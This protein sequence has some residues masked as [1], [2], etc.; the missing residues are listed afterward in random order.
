MST[1]IIAEAGVNHNGDL[2]L[3]KNLVDIAKNAEA[4]AVKFQTWKT[5][6]VMKRN[7]PKAEYQITNTGDKETQYE[8]EKKLELTYEE[9]IILKEY[10]DQKK[11]DFLS[12]PFD[13]PSA[14]FLI[15]DLSLKTIKIPSG[16]IT[17]GPLL[18][19][20]AKHKVQIILSTGMATVADIQLALGVIAFGLLNDA[21]KKPCIESFEQA[22]ISNKGQEIL[23]QYVTL[24][25]CTTEYPAPYDSVNLHIIPSL[26]QTFGLEVGYSDHTEG[27]HVS[28]AAVTLGATV[29]EK[30]I[31]YDKNAVGPDHRA[32]IEPKELI[33]LI[34][35][36]KEIEVA[37]GKSV[38]VPDLTEIKNRS[39]ARKSLV[40]AKDIKV[41]TYFNDDNLD[42]K[43][44]G[45]GL[46]PMYY[47]DIQKIKATKDFVFDEE[48]QIHDCNN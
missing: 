24:L 40:A 31:T 25:H 38:K 35:N 36:V 39:I 20:I 21:N 48:I 16:E 43:R 15:E 22:Y 18:Y 12:T 7:A 28:L 42:M 46:S 13:I 6:K 14:Q 26:K 9:F 2:Q 19:E 33:E 8:M 10:C 41:G 32:S 17:N 27:N 29:I 45:T 37:L 1:Y 47:W 11:I 34:K 4:N 3:A 5:E 23:K 30:H 44:P